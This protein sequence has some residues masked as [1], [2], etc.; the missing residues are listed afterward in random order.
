[1]VGISIYRTSPL[2]TVVSPKRK[3]R[4]V[5]LLGVVSG[6]R[7]HVDDNGAL[8]VHY[9]K[10]G[11]NCLRTFR[12]NLAVPSSRVKNVG[13]LTLEDGSDRS[14][15]NVRKKLHLLAAQ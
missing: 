8:L 6:F 11:V 9:A 15:R 4:S 10:G 3:L 2:P 5:G 1:M 7:R 13:F 14:H 12:Y